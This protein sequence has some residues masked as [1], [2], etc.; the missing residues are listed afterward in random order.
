MQRFSPKPRRTGFTLIEILVVVAI[1]GILA[2]MG[3]FVAA[4]QL[5]RGR[6]AKRISDIKAMQSALE[7]R[8]AIEGSYVTADSTNCTILQ[9][10]LANYVQGDPS[11]TGPSGDPYSCVLTTATYCICAT[12]EGTTQGNSANTLCTDWTG[13]THFCQVNQL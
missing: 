3:A 7:Q 9:T 6:D 4:T 10:D 11:F 13:T 12:L 8:M 1:I 2:T 5:P